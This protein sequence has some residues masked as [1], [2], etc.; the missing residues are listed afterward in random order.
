MSYY[1]G[2]AKR[3]DDIGSYA[4]D[5][6]GKEPQCGFYDRPLFVAPPVKAHPN[7]DAR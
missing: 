3:P 4:Y 5:T 2:D 7:D 1:V 6:E